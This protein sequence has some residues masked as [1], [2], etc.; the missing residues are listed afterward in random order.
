MKPNT[1]FVLDVFAE[2]RFS[3]NQLAVFQVGPEMDAQ[4]MQGIAR[5]TNYS[6]TTF[7]T[8]DAPEGGGYGVRIFT[9]LREVPFAGHPVLGTAYVIQQEV[10]RRPV[11]EVV[12]SLGE[13]MVPVRITYRNE[14]PDLL[15]MTQPAPSFGVHVEARE[16]ARALGLGVK[17]ID[18]RFPV[19]EVSTGLPFIIVP[20]RSLEAMRRIRINRDEYFSLI[21]EREAKAIMA[22]CPEVY[23]K[24]NHFNVRMF[25]EYYGIAEDPATGS[26]NGC[27][28]AYLA[29]HRYLGGPSVSARVEQGHEVGR[30]SLLFISA[31]EG[32]DGITVE[33]GGRVIPVMRGSLL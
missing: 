22:F 13:G 25:A 2:R 18:E 5:E 9:P 8:S 28:A 32:K 33:V 3:G 10:I 31:E 16:A 12:L 20:V 24:G 21:E 23:Q 6:E 17:D 26:G 27:L 14:R 29:R 15:V 4:T 11:G 7:V 1:Y 30:P 19:Q